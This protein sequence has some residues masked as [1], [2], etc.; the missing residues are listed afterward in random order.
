MKFFIDALMNAGPGRLAK[1]KKNK[2]Q[3]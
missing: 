3:G 2:G 1:E